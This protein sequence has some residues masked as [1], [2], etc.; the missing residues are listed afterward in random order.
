MFHRSQLHVR[1]PIPEEH[2]DTLVDNACII[3]NLPRDAVSAMTEN[4]F[5]VDFFGERSDTMAYLITRDATVYLDADRLTMDINNLKSYQSGE[6]EFKKMFIK[7]G[8]LNP[9][10]R[11]LVDDITHPCD[12]YVCI[13]NKTRYIT[14]AGAKFLLER[15]NV[16]RLHDTYYYNYNLVNSLGAARAMV[17]DYRAQKLKMI[18][19]IEAAIMDKYQRE[20]RGLWD[21]VEVG[22]A[23]DASEAATVIV[24]DMANVAA[25]VDA[26]D[27]ASSAGEALFAMVAVAEASGPI[28]KFRI[29]LPHISFII[30]PME[31]FNVSVNIYGND[32]KLQLIVTA[33]NEVVT[34][35][36]QWMG[37]RLG[38]N[39]DSTAS[40]I[41]RYIAKHKEPT[42]RTSEVALRELSIKVWHCLR[43]LLIFAMIFSY[44]QG[45]LD[46]YL[47]FRNGSYV[48]FT[49]RGEI[50]AIDNCPCGSLNRSHYVKQGETDEII[51]NSLLAEQR[52]LHK[53][54]M[55]A[56][57]KAVVDR[58]IEQH[59]NGNDGATYD[60][61][62]Q[63]EDELERPNAFDIEETS[64]L[65]E[66]SS[67]SFIRSKQDAIRMIEV[68]SKSEMDVAT[69][70]LNADIQ[71][72]A[73]IDTAVAFAA[74]VE[75]E[76]PFIDT[77]DASMGVV[78]ASGGSAAG[79]S[80]AIAKFYIT[81][82]PITVI[83]RPMQAFDVSVD[84]YGNDRQLK[85]VVTSNDEVVTH[86]V[87]WM[88][89]RLDIENKHAKAIVHNASMSEP[90]LHYE[91]NDLAEL[92]KEVSDSIPIMYASQSPSGLPTQR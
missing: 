51:I 18:E 67:T 64:Q 54:V 53:E 2:R 47:A 8:E 1:S 28:A 58:L 23:A 84:I 12:A 9:R 76:V 92:A 22:E 25:V 24:A 70:K 80:G 71:N 69:L 73:C 86:A 61:V 46:E 74:S 36:A 14:S 75:A 72:V 27:E 83:I 90:M 41:L 88:G 7:Y 78:K 82:P 62:L 60:H 66:I 4:A 79:S 68:Q 11:K 49:I 29:T 57:E 42:L 59:H 16:G 85:I 50:L 33:N 40:G 37:A 17:A 38:I 63:R 52:E 89:A 87:Q 43:P 10:K 3:V 77:V 91:M 30:R 31:T 55:Y 32:R 5:S 65:A 39:D 19:L 20:R 13:Y 48:C 34:Y 56:V 15:S 26:V 21:D 44:K 45:R 81:L 35:A 6:E